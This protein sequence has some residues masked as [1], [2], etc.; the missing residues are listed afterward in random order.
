[1]HSPS[2]PQQRQGISSRLDS[3]VKDTS[4]MAKRIS[5]VRGQSVSAPSSPASRLKHLAEDAQQPTSPSQPPS[6]PA[7][8]IL[9]WFQTQI[10]PSRPQTPHSAALAEAMHDHL[11]TRPEPAHLPQQYHAN[12]RP[13][14]LDELTRSTLPTSSLTAP[15]DIL[16][17]RL[18]HHIPEPAHPLLLNRIPPSPPAR[19][20]LDTIRTLYT[21]ATPVVPSH[22][23]TRNITIPTPFR[24]WFQTEPAKDGDKH[25]SILTDEDQDEDSEVERENIRK[26]CEHP[27]DLIHRLLS[28]EHSSRSFSKEPRRIL[29]WPSRLRLCYHRAGYRTAGGHPLARDQGSSP[30]RRSGRIDHPRSGNKQS[31]RQSASVGQTDIGSIPWT[32]DPPDRFVSPRS[33]PYGLCI[34]TQ[35]LFWHA[36]HSMVSSHSSDVV[37]TRV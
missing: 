2:D 21:K 6:G 37:A 12:I 16:A 28:V 19:T 11:P 15:S 30:V 4:K 20:S 5:I 29:P 24:N 3:L 33:V 18:G 27:A 7:S 14:M 8:P 10:S 13:P 32:E 34:Y 25:G 35:A 31:D 9:R 23:Q 1:M 26:K 36:G 17:D 22:Q